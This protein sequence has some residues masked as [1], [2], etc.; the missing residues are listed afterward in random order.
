MKD[1]SKIVVSKENGQNLGYVLDYFFDDAFNVGGYIVVEEESENEYFLKKADVKVAYNF[2]LVESV[3]SLQFLTDRETSLIGKTMLTSDGKNLGVIKGFDIKKNRC[4]RVWTDLCEIPSSKIG[5]VGKDFVF[6]GKKKQSKFS[7]INIFK[8]D[9]DAV[10]SIQKSEEVKVPEKLV[11]SA[12]HFLGKVAS[13]D[14]FG[15]NNERVIAKGEKVTKATVEKA[16]LHN[17]LNQ[18]YFAT[19]NWW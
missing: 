1:I 8:T 13:E 15:Y 18:L 6:V 4:H 11:L 19:K 17:R 7:K 14:V 16:K 10:V 9:V 2:L 12:E 5:K 3:L